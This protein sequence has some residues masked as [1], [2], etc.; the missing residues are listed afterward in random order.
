MVVGLK[1][2]AKFTG[3]FII[4]CCAVFV[5]TLFLNFNM[6]MAGIRD[7]I[8]PGPVTVFYEAQVSSGKMISC[9][10]GGCLL[11]TSVLML[12]FYIKHY[13]DSHRKELGILKALGYSD[14][15]IA[16]G[17]WVF[18]FSV[19]FGTGVGFG[20]AFLLMPRFYRVMNEENILPD[21]AVQFHFSLLVCLVLIP[22]AFFSAL[23][24][25]YAC[26][27][28]GSPVLTLLSGKQGGIF[29]IRRQKKSGRKNLSF[30]QD[31]R[32][33]TA[34]SR[35]S[36]VFFIGFASFCYSSMMQMT[37]GMDELASPMFTAIIF[38]IGIV[39][40]FTTLLLS[41]TTVVDSNTKTIAMMRV[42]GYSQKD[43]RKAILDGYRPVAYTGFA[44]G[45]AYQYGLVKGMVSIIFKDVPEV[46]DYTF[47]WQ[48]L[49]IT[50]LS[51]AVVY[52]CMMLC[53]SVR[54]KNISLKEIMLERV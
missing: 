28:L 2:A 50:L 26:R 12:F 16:R 20:G 17:F 9:V 3:I 11:L 13:I 44:I 33:S 48:A 40:S 41:V 6:D 8:A 52:E 7:E 37:F 1:D 25:L 46:P 18:G 34:R 47:N 29:K 53:Y 24:V 23:A 14:F 27:K 36:L 32:Q 49:F 22:A 42:F 51:F 19:L 5:C 10:S 15:K 35:I 45:T 54:I 4:S 30:L 31:L 43:C 38:V 21:I 39:L